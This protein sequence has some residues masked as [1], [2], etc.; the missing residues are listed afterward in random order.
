[1]YHF[2]GHVPSSVNIA[3]FALSHLDYLCGQARSN[4]LGCMCK[5]PLPLSISLGREDK[6]ENVRL[7]FGQV[8]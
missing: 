5:V 7:A 8:I 1:M 2:Y 4:V 6:Q 3:L